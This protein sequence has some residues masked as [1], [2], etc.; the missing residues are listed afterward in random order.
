MKL[1][2]PIH[3]PFV[4]NQP[5]H[6]SLAQPTRTIEKNNGYVFR[7]HQDGAYV[8]ARRMLTP[9][10]GRIPGPGYANALLV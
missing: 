2:L 10:A 6:A 8:M 5:L 1:W 7:I 4:P 3:G 9:S